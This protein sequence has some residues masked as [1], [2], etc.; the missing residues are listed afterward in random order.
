MHIADFKLKQMQKLV[1]LVKAII[2]NIEKRMPIAIVKDSFHQTRKAEQLCNVKLLIW[3]EMLDNFDTNEEESWEKPECWSP[4]DSW[5]YFGQNT[6]ETKRFQKES[7]LGA[8]D[9][10]QA[11]DTF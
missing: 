9:K 5:E 1:C 10:E 11:A 6:C 4:E 3:Q 2:Y 7:K 8:I